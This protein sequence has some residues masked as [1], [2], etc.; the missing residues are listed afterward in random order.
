MKVERH[1][2]TYTVR[3]LYAGGEGEALPLQ[4]ALQLVGSPAHDER[5][6][7]HRLFDVVV[8]SQ[9]GMDPVVSQ[10]AVSVN[11]DAGV[12]RGLHYQLPP[13]QEA[14]LVSC[15]QG[16]LLD[17]VVDL[18][19]GSPTWGRWATVALAGGDGRSVYVPRGFAHGYQTLV[20]GTVVH[21]TTSQPY[22][23]SKARA[24]RWNCECLGLSW[25]LPPHL[26]PRDAAAPRELP[27][28]PGWER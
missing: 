15:V 13:Y 12:L 7:F 11:H 28:L 25:P 27:R 20:P 3:T 4:G 22:E 10:V 8:M 24:V 19:D 23:P 6:D 21:Y 14:K 9:L 26:S 2:V 1:G 5:G 18:R 17:V 16:A